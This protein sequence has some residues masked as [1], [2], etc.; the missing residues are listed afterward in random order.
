MYKQAVVWVAL[1]VLAIFMYSPKP[2]AWILAKLHME[3]FMHGRWTPGTVK[4]KMNSSKYI[5]SIRKYPPNY[6]LDY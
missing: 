5:N 4:I 6:D 1:V 3:K 2:K